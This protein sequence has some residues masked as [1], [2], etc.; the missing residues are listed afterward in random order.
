[1]CR[2]LNSSRHDS[3]GFTLIEI[4]VALF[5]FTIVSVLMTTALHNLLLSQS[6]VEKNAARFAALQTSLL[7]LSRDIE[8][9]IDRSSSVPAENPDAFQGTAESITFT[10]TGLANPNAE[11]TRPTLQRIRY[12][13]DHSQL[14]RF[15]WPLP[16]SPPQTSPAQRMLLGQ[17]TRLEFAYLDKKGQFHNRWPLSGEEATPLPRGVRV[18]L[19]IEKMG[20]IEQLYPVAGQALNE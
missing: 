13:A 11:L 3:G 10:H 14:I 12:A 17:I 19:T 7:L 1:M 16:D 5:V 6:G 15:T 20:T 18:R 2:K 9:A 4:L 8:Q